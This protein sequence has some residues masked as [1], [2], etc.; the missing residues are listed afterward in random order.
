MSSLEERNTITIDSI[1]DLMI[2]SPETLKGLYPKAFQG[3]LVQEL[4]DL[5]NAKL[6]E[7][8]LFNHLDI[9]KLTFGF[10]SSLSLQKNQSFAIKTLID[11]YNQKHLMKSTDYKT[12]F[13]QFDI[14]NKYKDD[15]NYYF[16]LCYP[17]NVYKLEKTNR[18]FHLQTIKAKL[19]GMLLTHRY[20][21][22]LKFSLDNQH[23]EYSKEN[24]CLFVICDE[25]KFT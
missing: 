8:S 12:W 17:N 11:N 16:Y 4:S 24:K 18:T 22:I 3:K 13:I 1:E 2:Y 9:N 15:I 10:T 7:L 23:F 5:L 19:E 6:P 20:C 14:T 21:N 25:P